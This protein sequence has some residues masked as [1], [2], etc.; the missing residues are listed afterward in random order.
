[1]HLLRKCVIATEKVKIKDNAYINYIYQPSILLSSNMLPLTLNSLFIT[2]S[3]PYSMRYT[4]KF[5]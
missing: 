3:G 5:V 1:M 2:K 4:N